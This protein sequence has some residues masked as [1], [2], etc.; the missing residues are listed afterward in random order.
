[1]AVATPNRATDRGAR[2]LALPGVVL[3]V[4]L[5]ASSTA[6]CSINCCNGTTC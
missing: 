6:S 1:M 5:G 2:L 3:G 4:G